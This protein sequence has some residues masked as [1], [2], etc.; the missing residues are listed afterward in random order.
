M[1]KEV[2]TTRMLSVLTRTEAAEYLRISPRT[3]DTKL[4]KTG[5]I[6]KFLAGDRTVRFLQ[7][8]IDPK[9]IFFA[10][11]FFGKKNFCRNSKKV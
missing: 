1:K 2:F 8:D 3:L 7:V 5:K 11:R 6:R 9:L 10:A 4:V